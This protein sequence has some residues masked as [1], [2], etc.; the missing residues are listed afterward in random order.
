MNKGAIVATIDGVEK[1][2]YEPL[3][4]AV[5][6]HASTAPNL[7]ALGTRGTGKSLMLRWD[8]IIRCLMV[9]NFRALIVRRTMPELRRSHLAYIDYE[10]RM[11][12]GVFLNTTFTARFPNG[13][14]LVFAHCETEADVM[15]FLSSEYG[16]IGFDELST[17]TLDQFLKI[18]AAARAPLDA[19]YTAFVRAGSNPI[20]IG[21]DWMY[22][23]FVDKDV[24]L[25]DYP[26]Y[27][28]DE[29]E[30][31]FSTLEDNPTLDA[32]AYRARLKNLPEHMRRG[33]LL[34]ERV[35]EGMYFSDFRKRTEEGNPW[36]V[37]DEIPSWKGEPIYA[38][39]WLNV[40]RAVD[41]GYYP[42]PAVCLWFAV[43]PNKRTIVFKEMTWRRTLANKVAED[44][45]KASE[46]MHIVETF[47]DPTMEIKEGQ[48]Y[49][50]G[51]IF[52]QNG[53]PV[54]A[55]V[56]DR[57]LYGYSIHQYLNTLIDGLPQAQIVKGLGGFGCPQLIQTIP[58]MRT[59]PHDPSKLADGNDH[60][61]VAFAYFCMGMA[62]PS[63][64][65]AQP[66][67]HRWM[68]P[69]RKSKSMATC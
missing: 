35:T 68:M 42:D 8:A 33:W 32:T 21:A 46:G 19:G 30:M 18:S 48:E 29:F 10:M 60:Y 16:F 17:F 67:T 62:Q 14:T 15:N 2:L 25:D 11:L 58:Q 36:H 27:L 40:Y 23:W 59:H 63:K 43:L 56:N 51:E 28:P 4:H 47:C 57:V 12:G 5:K 55:S 53:V 49:S 54:T 66:P 65:P 6:F 26:D 22:S 13:S 44:I 24:H 3:D 50:I 1:V 9:P 20:G 34:G 38:H 61:V 64:D 69:K 39:P 45:K 7:L 37:I 41:W 31:Q 52:E